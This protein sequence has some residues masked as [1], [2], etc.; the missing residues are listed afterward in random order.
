MFVFLLCFHFFFFLHLQNIE[1]NRAPFIAPPTSHLAPSVTQHQDQ[2]APNVTN[3]RAHET[4][5]PS[6][7]QLKFDDIIIFV[8]HFDTA[9][10]YNSRAE[11]R[12]PN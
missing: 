7:R 4:I 8:A 6:L 9:N 10:R 1:H 3:A 12:N 11:K 5:I 2:R